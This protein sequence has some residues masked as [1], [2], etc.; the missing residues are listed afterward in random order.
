MLYRPFLKKTFRVIVTAFLYLF[1]YLFIFFLLRLLTGRSH[2]L[3]S[4]F[5][6]LVVAIYFHE[7]TTWAIRNF[8]DRTFYRIIFKVNTSLNEFNIEL[9]STLD[10]QQLIDKFIAFLKHT[11]PA[12]RW[13]FYLCWGED[14]ELFAD[15]RVSV[16]LP[17]LV[18]LPDCSTMDR[19]TRGEADFHSFQ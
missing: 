5:I 18:K 4:I 6:M 14:Y 9:N 15:N 16:G 13:A 2:P 11:F 1:Y 12:Q 10:Y 7:E 19:I 8:I 3:T 17:Q